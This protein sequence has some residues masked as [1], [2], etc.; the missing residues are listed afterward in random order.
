[1]MKQRCSLSFRAFRPGL[2][3]RCGLFLRHVPAVLFVLLLS[4]CYLPDRFDA[5]ISLQEEGRVRITFD[6]QLAWILGVAEIFHDRIEPDDAEFREIAGAM[7]KDPRVRSASYL[8]DGRFDI[9]YV[10]TDTLKPGQKMVFPPMGPP[11]FEIVRTR[12]GLIR[13]SGLQVLEQDGRELQRVGLRLR[14][15]LRVNTDLDIVEQ[16]GR[17]DSDILQSRYVWDF[18]TLKD[19]RP[20]L[21]ALLPEE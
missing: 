7:R 12:D 18:E 1:M 11:L 9:S 10:Q 14:G 3:R 13:V 6:G 4:C 20:Y 5:V 16:N 8:G 17:D 2:V 19:P 21:T 15:R